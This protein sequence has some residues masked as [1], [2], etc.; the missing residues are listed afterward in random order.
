MQGAQCTFVFLDAEVIRSGRYEAA[1]Y[2]TLP[3]LQELEAKHPE[4]MQKQLL[5]R[6]LAYGRH[7]YREEILAVSHRWEQPDTPDPSGVQLQ[8]IRE[9]LQVCPSIKL[10]WY[11]FW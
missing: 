7:A 2:A 8:A 5:Q 11:D 4:W 3:R 6:H 10:V 1:G 9:H